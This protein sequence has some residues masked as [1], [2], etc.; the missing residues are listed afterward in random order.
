MGSRAAMNCLSA[1]VVEDQR[2]FC[3]QHGEHVRAVFP[4]HGQ[5]YLAVRTALEG[6]ALRVKLAPLSFSKP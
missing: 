4:V 5:Q 6:I 3:V 2:E 1:R